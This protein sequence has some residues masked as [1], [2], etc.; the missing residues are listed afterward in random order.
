MNEQVK[1]VLK[2]SN[3]NSVFSSGEDE[4]TTEIRLF[5]FLPH[6]W[7]FGVGDPIEPKIIEKALEIH[8][9]GIYLGLLTEAIPEVDGGITLTFIYGEDSVEVKIHGNLTYSVTYERGIGLRFK[10]LSRL[11]NVDDLTVMQWLS[12]LKNKLKAQYTWKLFEGSR[13][14]D[15]A[16]GC[17]DSSSGLVSR[18]TK[19]TPFQSCHWIVSFGTPATYVVT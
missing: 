2:E 17:K 14:I 7:D 13:Q 9:R 12:K 6:G 19:M 10:R 15:I 4:I 5:A 18:I 1:Y 3:I 8:E 16:R 11:T